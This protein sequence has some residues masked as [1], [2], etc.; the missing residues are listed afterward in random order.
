MQNSSFCT[1]HPSPV[2]V[3]NNIDTLSWVEINYC[4]KPLFI[5]E[6]VEWDTSEDNNNV[7]SNVFF[8]VANS[9]R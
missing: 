5:N 1:A 6:T 9:H 2:S 8:I 4:K 3:I 7:V